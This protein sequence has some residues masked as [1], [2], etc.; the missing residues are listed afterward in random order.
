M[1][2]HPHGMQE[3]QSQN[4]RQYDLTI[5]AL[6]AMTQTLSSSQPLA[7]LRSIILRFTMCGDQ[8]KPLRRL[9]RKF[10]SAAAAAGGA[11]E[12]DVKP[13][14]ANAHVVVPPIKRKNSHR[15]RKRVLN[16]GA[17]PTKRVRQHKSGPVPA[18]GTV[19]PAF[20]IAACKSASQLPSFFES[21][22]FGGKTQDDEAQTWLCDKVAE[23]GNRKLFTM[24]LHIF[25]YHVL[26]PLFL[27]CA[28]TFLFT[29]C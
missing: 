27:P 2:E 28:S 1:L 20:S 23:L 22:H 3:R 11:P 9:V 21:K 14:A 6:N 4:K 16:A 12:A 29:M 24:C 8:E 19:K 18:V 25:F 7:I 13:A 17:Q 10:V 26:T 15:S 5:R